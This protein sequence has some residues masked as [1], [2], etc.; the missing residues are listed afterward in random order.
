MR[1]WNRA[2][3]TSF[4]YSSDFRSNHLFLFFIFS[5]TKCSGFPEFPAYQFPKF[6][7]FPEFPAYQFPKFPCFPEFPAYQIP[8]YPGLPNLPATR[9]FQ[10]TKPGVSEPAYQL[11]G[12]PAYQLAGYQ[13]SADRVQ[14]P[15][16]VP[17]LTGTAYQPSLTFPCTPPTK[18]ISSR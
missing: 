10:P 11:A 9:G 8:A 1:L 4:K 18:N 6:P 16:L 7:C 2:T 13:L 5:F 12:F 15:C 3:D 17:G 14:P